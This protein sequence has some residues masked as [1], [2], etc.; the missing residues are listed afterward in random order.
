[1]SKAVEHKDNK[2][3]YID[4]CRAYFYAKAVR[5]TYIKLPSEDPRSSEEGL[6]GKLMMSMYGTR[7]AAQNWAE[8]YSATLLKANF[9]RGKANPCLFYN[10]KDDC[11]VMVHGDDFVAVG[12]KAATDKLKKTLEDAYKVKC[13]VL[14]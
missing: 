8:E 2:V 12:G 7:D 4:V 5:P 10:H 11:S 3:L 9:I 1:M 13:E 14:G 6:V